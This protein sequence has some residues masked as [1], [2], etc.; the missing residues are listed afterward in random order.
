MRL[1]GQLAAGDGRFVNTIGG[2]SQVRQL[3][4]AGEPAIIIVAI[5]QNH[6]DDVRRIG[7]IPAIGLGVAVDQGFIFDASKDGAAERCRTVVH[8]G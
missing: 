1:Q 6:R 5:L 3:V 2:L 7:H 8:L 4:V